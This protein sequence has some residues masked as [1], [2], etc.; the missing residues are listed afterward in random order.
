M[1][2]IQF[3]FIRNA[4]SKKRVKFLP[5]VLWAN[6]LRTVLIYFALFWFT[7]LCFGLLY[8]CFDLPHFV[9]IDFTLF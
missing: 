7:S 1:Y 3:T 5:T 4:F 9:L 8:F 6:Y 2:V